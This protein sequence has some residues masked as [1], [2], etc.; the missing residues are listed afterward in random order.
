MNSQGLQGAL[1]FNGQLDNYL[2]KQ[3]TIAFPLT[4]AATKRRIFLYRRQ[5]AKKLLELCRKTGKFIL[6][7]AEK[8]VCLD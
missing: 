5:T 3:V 8:L 4:G 2:H 1:H 7:C 6:V